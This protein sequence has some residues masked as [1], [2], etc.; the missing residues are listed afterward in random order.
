VFWLRRIPAETQIV[1][2]VVFLALL[3]AILLSVFGLGAIA[4]ERR[5]QLEQLSMTARN[6]LRVD[7]VSRA[8]NRLRDH[9]EEVYRVA[10]GPERSE[11]RDRRLG[12]GLFVDA[13]LVRPDGAILHPDGSPLVLPPPAIAEANLEARAEAMRRAADYARGDE[14]G[15][16]RKLAGDVAFARRYPF[17]TDDRG[18]SLAMLFAASPLLMGEGGPDRATLLATRW[19]GVL[20][21]L[22]AVV[23]PIEVEHFLAAVDSAAAEVEDWGPSVQAQERAASRLAALRREWGRFEPD[24]PPVLHRNVL[25]PPEFPFYLRRLGLEGDW[26]VLAVDAERF[27]KFL[28]GIETEARALAEPGI[29]PRI[30]EGNAATLPSPAVDLPAMPGYAAWAKVD[31][32]VAD[33]RGGGRERFYWWI[34][35]FSVAGIFAGGLLTARAVIREVKLAKLKSGFVSNVSHELKTPLTSIRMFAEMLRSGKVTEKGEQQECLD[36][37]A[38]ETDRLGKLIQQVL[39]FGRLQSDK[40]RFRWTK[41]PLAPVVL[42]EAQRFRRSAGLGEEEFEVAIADNQPLVTHDPEAFGEVV[43]NLLSNAWKYSPPEARRIRLELGPRRGRLVLAVED[44]GP[45]VSPRERRKIFEQFYRAQDLL[46]RDVE[47]TGLGLSIT[48]SIVR[49]HGGRIH[50]EPG[51][52]GGARFVVILPAAQAEKV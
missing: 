1:V 31:A 4:N 21:R 25:A 34:I 49:A 23:S 3:Q 16:S 44:N 43:M 22:A 37:I 32:S 38:S 42:E 52:E 28:S 12:G 48:R 46:T 2:T 19:V 14:P 5:N 24:G 13:Y 39:D 20:N 35:A 18:E 8:Q 50:V 9:A 41:A 51:D 26:Q 11:W 45:G 40:R 33:V 15:L 47:G 30:V 36:V 17:A 6:Y 27:S 7:L 10:F 29:E